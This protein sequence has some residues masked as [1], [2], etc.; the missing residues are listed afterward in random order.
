MA[1][2]HKGEAVYKLPNGD[3]LPLVLGLN[4][5]AELEDRYDLKSVKEIGTIFDNMTAKKL[6]VLFY[7]L[8]NDGGTD[9]TEK[10]VGRIPIEIDKLNASVGEAI[11]R[12]FP[13]EKSSSGGSPKK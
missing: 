3:E 8:V 6:L 5:L 2:K 13:K 1:N 4:T 9:M 7:L 12:A 11:L 10:E